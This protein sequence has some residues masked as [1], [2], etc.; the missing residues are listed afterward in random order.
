MA[1]PGRIRK[2][3]GNENFEILPVLSNHFRL[4]NFNS[5]ANVQYDDADDGYCNDDGRTRT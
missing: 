4:T 3:Q 2:N 1:I 5:L